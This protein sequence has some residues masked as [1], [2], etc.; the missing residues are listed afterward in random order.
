MA[1]QAPTPMH[2]QLMSKSFRKA[3]TTP[4]VPIAITM[5]VAAY[6][7]AGAKKDRKLKPNPVQ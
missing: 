2:G 6:V 4:T 7:T 1:H 5:I 3:I